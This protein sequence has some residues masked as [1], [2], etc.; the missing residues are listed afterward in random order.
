[1]PFAKCPRVRLSH[2]NR[3][4]TIAMHLAVRSVRLNLNNLWCT[5]LRAHRVGRRALLAFSL[6]ANIDRYH[7]HFSVPTTL[8]VNIYRC[9]PDC[10]H[11][12]RS[13]N[14]AFPVL[15]LYLCQCLC[16]RCGLTSAIWNNFFSDWTIKSV[17]VAKQC[18]KYKMHNNE[19]HCTWLM[20]STTMH[21]ATVAVRVG[22]NIVWLN[23]SKS[24]CKYF[25]WLNCLVWMGVKWLNECYQGQ[26]NN[27]QLRAERETDKCK[28][29]MMPAEI[30][31]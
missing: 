7:L 10:W 24:M 12:L 19:F 6:S 23:F 4:S 9:M 20:T 2:H 31:K 15:L 1:M 18:G 13:A 17:N 30:M 16:I 26:R 27:K 8:S 11:S 28:S 22:D 5:F 14:L 29:E 21:S 25:N 3:N